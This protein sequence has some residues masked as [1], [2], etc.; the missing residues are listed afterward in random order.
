MT[1]L[2]QIFRISNHSIP[3]TQIVREVREEVKEGEE[4]EAVEIEEVV[5]VESLTIISVKENTIQVMT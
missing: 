3:Q 5:A 4:A 2:S 1:W